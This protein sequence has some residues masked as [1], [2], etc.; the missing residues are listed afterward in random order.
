MLKTLGLYMILMKQVFSRP[1]KRKLLWRQLID[2]IDR[3]GRDSLVIVAIISIFMGAAAT[4]QLQY[5]TDS[6]FIP[7]Y[8]IGFV[9]RKTIIM[10]FAPT[11]VSLLLAGKI[12]SRMASEI[13]TMKVSEQIDAL[14]VMGINAPNHIILPKIVATMIFNPI[15][16]M[17]SITVALF[18]GYFVCINSGMNTY[19][20]IY[21]LQAFPAPQD[22]NI[23][24]AKTVCNAF[25]IASVSS[26]YGY[27]T[28]GGAIEVGQSSTKAT[29]NSCIL[30]IICNL[31]L[32]KLL[33]R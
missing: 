25:I 4:L 19:E 16:I 14:E 10:E 21:G 27:H 15:L 8:M 30:I 17:V 31:V 26:F 3:M 29:V 23:S 5:N 32:T 12:G 33:L 11:I 22:I 13:G 6:P 7:K 2:E 20:F 24:M 28:E 1:P 18:G 9:A